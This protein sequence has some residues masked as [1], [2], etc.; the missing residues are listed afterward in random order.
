MPTGRNPNRPYRRCAP[1]FVTRTSSETACPP[2]SIACV[3][4][5]AA[6]GAC[7]CR[8]VLLRVDRDVRDVRLVP[9]ADQPP[10]ADDRLVDLGHQ[11]AAVRRLGHLG[12]EQV[13]APRTGVDLAL[14]RHHAAQVAPAHARDLQPRGPVL[15]DPTR[16]QHRTSSG[17]AARRRTS[18]SC[19]SRRNRGTA[20]S[21]SAAAS[22]CAVMDDANS[23]LLPIS[24]EHMSIQHRTVAHGQHLAGQS[25]QLG[26]ESIRACT[27]YSRS[28]ITPPGTLPVDR[29]EYLPAAR[30]DHGDDR[31]ASSTARRTRAR[32]GS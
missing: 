27:S 8:A 12:D 3:D 22:G 11:V 18:R 7:R 28:R 20:S 29:G 21:T 1:Q 6:A 13:R 4:E 31:S 14:D 10:V 16:S 25:L 5:L 26:L 32:R 15:A 30:V 9:V 23:I 2:I 24:L 19:S 17:R